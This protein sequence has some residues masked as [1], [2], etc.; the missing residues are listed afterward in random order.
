[1][2]TI[3]CLLTC[4]FS[5]SPI[6]HANDWHKK[7]WLMM[8]CIW[9]KHVLGTKYQHKNM[10][11]SCDYKNNSVQWLN[12]Y[13]KHRYNNQNQ[14]NKVVSWRNAIIKQRNISLLLP[15]AYTPQL[16]AIFPTCSLKN[17]DNISVNECLPMIALIVYYGKW[18]N[19]TAMRKP[20]RITWPCHYNSW[21]TPTLQSTVLFNF[22]R[23][24]R[25]KLSSL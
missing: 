13:Q 20:S 9:N 10:Y 8:E 14:T 23:S 22:F 21:K 19:T 24:I 6:T 17:T 15:G 16:V 3:C 2:C 5:N 25:T 7:H 1:M 12:F 4:T 11:S 18:P